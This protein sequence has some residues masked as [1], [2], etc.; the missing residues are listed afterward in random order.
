MRS[1][2]I[3]DKFPDC[4]NCWLSVKQ[5]KYFLLETDFLL[6]KKLQIKSLFSRLAST[7]KDDTVSDNE[8]LID[9]ENAEAEDAL[10]NALT[11]AKSTMKKK[12]K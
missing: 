12:R 9:Y 6:I 5:V 11:A 7:A 8:H 3:R 4:E 1:F 10:H 2:V